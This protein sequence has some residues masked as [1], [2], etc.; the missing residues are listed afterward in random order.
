MI[1]D[2]LLA[3]VFAPV[4]LFLDLLPSYTWP[5]WLEGTATSGSDKTTLGE[6]AWEVGNYL[7]NIDGW[8]P[9][10]TVLSC[11]TILAG[12]TAVALAIRLVRLAQSALTGGGGSAA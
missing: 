3:I 10:S 9:I 6:V 1:L 12:V 4:Q 2:A 7:Q 8:I 5:D 11:L